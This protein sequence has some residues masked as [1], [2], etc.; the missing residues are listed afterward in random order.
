MPTQNRIL[1]VER[2]ATIMLCANCEGHFAVD[3]CDEVPVEE[4]ECIHCQR[5]N[6]YIEQTGHRPAE[7]Y[8]IR[9]A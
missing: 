3:P 5:V 2:T 7:P 6:T 8:S 4:A 1:R 9:N